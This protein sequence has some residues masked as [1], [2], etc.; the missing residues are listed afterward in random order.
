M[1]NGI[2]AAAATM[3]AIYHQLMDT[4]YGALLWL[5]LAILA[6]S[7]VIGLLLRARARAR[8]QRL[9][10]TPL[11]KHWQTIFRAVTARYP[12]MPAG[13]RSELRGRVNEFVADKQFVGCNGLEITDE[14]RVT[15]AT[16]ACLLLLNRNVATFPNVLTILVY[17]SGFVAEFEAGEDWLQHEIAEIRA[18]ESW[19]RGPL[20]LAWDEVQTDRATDDERNLIIHEFAHKLDEQ[21]PDGPGLP[22]LDNHRLQADWS[23]IMQAEFDALTTATQLGDTTLIDPYGAESPAEFFAVLTESFFG[24]AP[25]LRNRHPELYSTLRGFFRVDPADWQ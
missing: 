20:I 16:H 18:G 14:I 12:R 25:A 17:P 1:R 6:S 10:H 23:R 5:S 4:P 15:V 11:P 8:R 22:P 9:Q 3:R 21:N 2:A 24:G 19:E 13:L 7:I